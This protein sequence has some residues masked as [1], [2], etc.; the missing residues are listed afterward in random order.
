MQFGVCL[1]NI[2]M[3]LWW[4]GGWVGQGGELQDEEG[5]VSPQQVLTV[6]ERDVVG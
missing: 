4:V 5:S 3:A 6:L 1:T 2:Q